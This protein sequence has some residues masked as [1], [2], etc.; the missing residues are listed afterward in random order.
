MTNDAKVVN[1]RVWLGMVAMVCAAGA[2]Q[3]ALAATYCN[4]GVGDA[5]VTKNAVSDGQSTSDMTYTPGSPTP[6]TAAKDCYGVVAG[7]GQLGND[8]EGA[9]N[10]LNWGTG[11]QLAAKDNTDSSPDASN[12]VANVQWSLTDMS[13]VGGGSWTLSGTGAG[14]PGT[15]DFVGVLK[16]SNGYAAYFFDD[17]Y[18]DG[19]GGGSFTMSIATGNGNQIAGLSHMTIYA[20]AGTCQTDC[21]GGG[22]GGGSAPEPASL[23]LMATALLGLG[24]VRRRR[25]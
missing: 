19:S 25:L 23:A 10:S 15:F 6:A 14:V 4:A 20:R 16:G 22:G 2:Y 18:F 11:W 12:L 1:S 5:D 17:V 13:N 24:A 7:Q 3:P 21:G 9:I 8:T